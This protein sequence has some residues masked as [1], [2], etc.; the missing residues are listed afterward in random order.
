MEESSRV[1]ASYVSGWSRQTWALPS[2]LRGQLSEGQLICSPGK[3][4]YQIEKRRLQQL[5]A[6]RLQTQAAEGIWKVREL[7]VYKEQPRRGGTPSV[8][9]GRPQEG[10]MEASLSGASF[11]LRQEGGKEPP[12][13]P[14][15]P[16]AP[17][18][19]RKISGL[20]SSRSRSLFSAHPSLPA[21]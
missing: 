18:L 16:A 19:L 20:L 21:A 8:P 10:L 15:P 5:P 9:R 12:P 3:E 14:P 17:P 11:R 7:N 4:E 6:L 1:G 2:A 13:P